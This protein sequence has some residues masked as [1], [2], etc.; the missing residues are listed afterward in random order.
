MLTWTTSETKTQF[1]NV[2]HEEIGPEKNEIFIRK[3][4]MA[5][6]LRAKCVSSFKE[7]TVL[8]AV[9]SE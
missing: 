3:Q 5:T 2:V 9:E 6:T 1:S 7:T 4:T 8:L